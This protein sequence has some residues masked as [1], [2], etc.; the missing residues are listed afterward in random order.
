MSAAAAEPGAVAATVSVVVQTRVAAGHDQDFVRW[1][2][3]LFETVARFPGYIDHAVTPPNPPVQVD[4]V[5][6]FRFATADAARGWLNSEERLK[7]LAEIQPYLVGQDDVH[8]FTDTDGPRHTPPVTAIISMRILPEQEQAFLEWQR[9]IDALESTFPGFEGYRLE[10]PVPGVQDDWV[11]VLRFDTDE[12]LENWLK[13]PERARI[14]EE[15]PKFT[16][17]FHVRKAHTGFE[18]WFMS[19][20]PPGTEPPAWWKMD[21]IVLMMLY[22]SVAFFNVVIGKPILGPLGVPFWLQLFLGN[23]FTTVF[24][25]WPLVPKASEVL[26]WWLHPKPNSPASTRLAGIAAVAVVYLVCMLVISQLPLP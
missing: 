9:R 7:L 24:L 26:D 2:D 4:W 10:P 25:A 11:S 16:V 3:K 5:I 6:I 14:L 18:P 23:V 17:P 1:Q 15:A 20:K 21:M 12:H 13:S 8:L 19:G 22:P